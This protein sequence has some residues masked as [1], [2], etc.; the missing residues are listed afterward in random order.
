MKRWAV[1]VLLI[2]AMAA[3]ACVGGS[4]AKVELTWDAVPGV[5]GYNVYRGAQPGGEYERINAAPVPEPRYTD[6]G[7]EK[8]KTYFYRV[9]AVNAAGVESEYSEERSRT[10]Q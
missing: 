5:A 6:V 2:G 10:V 9:T 8:G 1:A 4:T 7:V 3:F